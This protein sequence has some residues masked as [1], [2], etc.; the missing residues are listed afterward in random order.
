VLRDRLP[1]QA[2]T[3][4]PGQEAMVLTAEPQAA[5]RNAAPDGRF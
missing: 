4:A 1:Q 5:S 3:D 2:I